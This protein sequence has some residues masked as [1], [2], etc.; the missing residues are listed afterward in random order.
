MVR[1]NLFESTNRDRD[2]E[3]KLIDTKGGGGW[4]VVR[5]MG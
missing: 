2:L 1:M 3:N 5:R 4:G